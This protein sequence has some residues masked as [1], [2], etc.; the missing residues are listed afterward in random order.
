MGPQTIIPP[1]YGIE[2]D[3]I[4]KLSQQDDIVISSGFRFEKPSGFNRLRILGVN[5]PILLSIPVKKHKAGI[6]VSEIE[7]D[8]LQKWQNQH[9]R[10]IQSAYG[11]SPY[12]EYF[13]SDLKKIYGASPERLIEFTGILMKWVLNQYFPE[14]KITV[15]LAQNQPVFLTTERLLLSWKEDKNRSETRIRYTQVFG[16]EFVSGMSVLDHLFCEGTKF[17]N[18]QN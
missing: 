8:Y 13:K 4:L 5:G 18:L 2:A 6:P 17:W 11:K 1:L 9:W 16:Q 7:I 10:S 14:K 12:F 15:I 3:D